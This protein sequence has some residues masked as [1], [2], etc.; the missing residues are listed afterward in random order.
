MPRTAPSLSRRLRLGGAAL[1]STALLASCASG[2][3]E[4]TSAEEGFPVTVENCGAEV[5]FD[6]PPEQAILL[7][8]SAVPFLAEL[9]VLDRVSARAGAYPDEY[10]D[11]QTL[12]ALE[13]I[14]VLTD[15]LDT[16]GHLQISR[17]VVVAQTPDLVLGEVDNLS[18]E[19]LS[20]VDIPLLEEP[21]LCDVAGAE[22]AWDD[23]WSQLRLYGRVFAREDEAEQAVADLQER[24]GELE[25][26]AAA[27][28]PRTAAVLYPGVGGG[29]TYAYG[30]G[31]MAQPQLESAGLTNVFDDVDERVFEVGVEELLG[32]DPDVLVLLHSEGDPADVEQAVLDLPGAERLAAVRDDAVQT[33]LFNFTEPASPLALDGL[34][35]I[36][37][38]LPS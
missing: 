18:R 2:A 1:L 23:V 14:P 11:A 13:E 7:K 19:S 20:S 37:D 33:L 4:D 6:A 9:G 38:G 16:S 17:E 8:S 32:R 31:S 21:A 12:A 22:P 36:L 30:T 10:Y 25:A 28:E 27:R 15:E 24:L 26:R 35:R 34:E 29:A 3:A 5:T